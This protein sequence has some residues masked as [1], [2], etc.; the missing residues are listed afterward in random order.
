MLYICKLRT[1]I[2]YEK[3]E[4][5]LTRLINNLLSTFSYLGPTLISGST[6]TF[7][8]EY[9]LSLVAKIANL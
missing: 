9:H 3:Y 2:G 1:E 5:E 6:I 4:E 8:I 7:V